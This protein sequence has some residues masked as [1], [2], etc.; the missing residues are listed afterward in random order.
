MTRSEKLR[1]T[2]F[3]Q[4]VMPPLEGV[5]V[6]A[7]RVEITYLN[8]CAAAECVG[9]RF[10]NLV[11]A[12]M[13][14]YILSRYSL[15]FDDGELLCGRYSADFAVPED[16]K[17]RQEVYQKTIE[18][19]GSRS[20]THT[21]AT[22]HRA[23]DYEKLLHQGVRGVL[24]EIDRY[25][26]AL[27]LTDPEYAQKQIF[28]ES[29][30]ISLQAFAAFG[31]RY[32]EA[33]SH[34][35]AQEKDPVRKKELLAMA[36]NF[37]YAPYEPCTHFYEAVQC[38]W[39]IQFAL[40]LFGDVSLTGRMDNYLWPYYE[41]DVREGV[42]TREFAFEIIENLYYKHNEVHGTWPA[43]IMLGGVD[44]EGRP[45]WN[46][47][48]RMCLD[49]VES[50]KL[51][52]PAVAVCYT[53][54]MPE[55]I[56]ER[57]VDLLARGYTRPALFNHCIIKKGL[58]AA[59]VSEEDSNQYIQS[60]CVEITPVAASN[61]LV[62]TPY[63]NLNKSLE[64]IFG[65][66]KAIFGD[67]CRLDGEETI[68][69]EALQSFDN[70]F[71]LVKAVIRRILRYHVKEVLTDMEDRVRHTSCPLSS[72][73]LNDCLKTGKDAASGGARY[74]FVYPTF[75][76]FINLI[77]S[78]A[79]VRQ[80]V[81]EEKR[82]TLSQM[83]EL[84]TSNFENDPRMLAYVRN[85]CPK[86][87]NGIAS[88][89]ALGRELFDFI[90]QE[91]SQYQTSLEGRFYPSYF[92]WIM[93]GVLGA[94]AGATPD[95]RRSTQALSECLGSVQGMDHS[96]PVGVVDSIEKLD[97]SKGIGG[98]ATNFRFSANMLSSEKGRKGLRDFIRNF[99][100]RDCFEIQ[101]NVVSQEQLLE[102]QKNPEQYRT[103]M[104]R[105]AGYSDYFVNL[106]PIIQ[107]EIISRTEH[108][109]I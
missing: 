46:D 94:V 54:Q 2:A 11:R 32:F 45:V 61:I 98:I 25:Q 77:D 68:D 43:S 10:H 86:F 53:E 47:L 95:G 62:A 101:I 50:T 97:Q 79:A 66:G 64:Y 52:N 29:C 16:W 71:G 26:A 104:V 23:I 57:C 106:S 85:R 15:E 49:A 41:K 73:F 93:H 74:N 89:D 82:L 4:S 5:D 34:M 76:G 59:G 6:P 88:V 84:C 107:N 65:H 40:A 99:M 19:L 92:A 7:N 90:Y 81:Y 24:E 8:Y 48:T 63:I 14:A 38:I 96:G 12:K 28:Y 31:R 37:R 27:E 108:G 36:E 44:R 58:L 21:G 33:L 69:F 105:V 56:L 17:Q 42:L 22:Y 70:F 80:T 55:D 83:G 35:A 51:V 87:G 9:E 109:A 13:D 18:P 20:G 30:C 3:E 102:A 75:P 67:P 100:S 72:P 78:L 91:L 103:L 39:L 1:N 60:T